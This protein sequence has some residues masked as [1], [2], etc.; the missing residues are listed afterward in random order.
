VRWKV[1][2]SFRPTWIEDDPRPSTQVWVPNF[3]GREEKKV[4]TGSGREVLKRQRR[5]EVVRSQDFRKG[6]IH[7]KPK[8]KE[9]KVFDLWG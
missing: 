3:R 2:G 8:K 6:G 1:V 7:K 4:G 9:E 5:E